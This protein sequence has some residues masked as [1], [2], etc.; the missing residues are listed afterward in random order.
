MGFEGF[1]SELKGILRQF[2]KLVLYEVFCLSIHSTIIH[3][4][5]NGPARSGLR[6]SQN[7]S[8]NKAT[9]L[10]DF[11]QLESWRTSESTKLEEFRPI[12]STD[13]SSSNSVL[14]LV[15][16]DRNSP[17]SVLSHLL[18]FLQHCPPNP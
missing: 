15:Y 3:F 9:G 12:K 4:A 10:E 11:R 6:I 5:E 8:K 14:V 7:I 17:H 1:F 18:A 16:S 13:R 2:N